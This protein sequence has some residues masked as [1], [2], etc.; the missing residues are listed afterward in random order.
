MSG[1][2]IILA[3]MFGPPALFFYLGYNAKKNRSDDPNVKIFYIIAIVYLIV[4]LGICGNLLV[5]F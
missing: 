4:G 3:I 2:L 5:S 1:I